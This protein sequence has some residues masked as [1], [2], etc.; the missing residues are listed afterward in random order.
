[1]FKCR[2]QVTS[3]VVAEG[4]GSFP[5]PNLPSPAISVPDLA[6]DGSDPGGG[7]TVMPQEPR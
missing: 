6:L 7:S 3:P 4:R 2:E 1:M 5:E